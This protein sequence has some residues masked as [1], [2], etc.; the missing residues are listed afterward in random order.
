MI[1]THTHSYTDI[2]THK[3][4]HNYTHMHTMAYRD[5]HTVAHR[6]THAYT[7]THTRVCACVHHYIYTFSRLDYYPSPSCS[8]ITYLISEKC[9]VIMTEAVKMSQARGLSHWVEG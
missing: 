6:H 7:H 3:S 9:Q 5:S 2:H 1:Q 4:T 8:E